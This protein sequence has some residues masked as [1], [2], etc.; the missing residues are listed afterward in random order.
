[1]GLSY[2]GHER[3]GQAPPRTRK[4]ERARIAQDSL[5]LCAVTAPRGVERQPAREGEGRLALFYSLHEHA[6]RRFLRPRPERIDDKSA[7]PA[8]QPGKQGGEPVRALDEGHAAAVLYVG[9][10]RADPVR[11]PDLP[12]HVG[13]TAGLLGRGRGL[14]FLQ[15]GRV[16]HDV[17]E[18]G[19]R[20][21]RRRPPQVADDRGEALLQAVDPR[22]LRRQGHQRALDID[23]RDPRLGLARQKTEGRP[24]DAAAQVQ[25]A[26]SRTGGNGGGQEHAVDGDPE[27]RARLAQQQTPAQE[28]VLADLQT[29]ASFRHDTPG[30]SSPAS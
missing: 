18:A 15:V 16:G 17:I 21:A 26:L 7:R 13:Q 25:Q 30:S 9:E 29:G 10:R 27:S 11:Q 24:A 8:L 3:R 5:G 2:D 14:A 4:V 28:T 22:V 23:P 6:P 1:M 19:G 20:N 12:L